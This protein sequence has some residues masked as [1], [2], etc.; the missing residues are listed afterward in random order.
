M[1]QRK[2]KVVNI[3]RLKIALGL[4]AAGLLSYAACTA[5]KTAMKGP[6]VTTTVVKS[7][8]P[9]DST[10][11]EVPKLV[12]G[13]FATSDHLQTVYFDLGKSKL[14]DAGLETVKGNMEWLKTQ[15]PFLIRI[16]GYSDSRGSTKKNERLAS[17][18][19]MSVMDEYV[20]MGLPKERI[21]FIGRGEEDASCKPMT[22]ECLTKSRRSETLIEEKSLASR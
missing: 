8:I 5:E 2:E 18:R 3:S 16:I 6:D 4:A 21:S 11:K 17:R 22:E 14:S 12:D 10:I 13:V 19:A 1:N 20:S 9:K 7:D 15:P